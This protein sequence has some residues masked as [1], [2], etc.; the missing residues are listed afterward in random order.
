MDADLRTVA[1]SSVATANAETGQYLTFLLDGEEYGV[2]ILRVQEIK[3]WEMVTE[4]PNTPAYLRGVINLRGSIVPIIDL[5]LRFQM[6]PVEYGKTTVVIVLKVNS[7]GAERTVGFV[8]DAV[9]DVCNIPA[10]DLRRPPEF[11]AAVR[12]EFVT[13]LAIVADKMIVLLDIDKLID[14]DEVHADHVA[15]QG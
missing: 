2:N 6:E 10:E 1:S 3:G 4:I 7:S 15:A 5:R 9:S 8:V 11:G 13:G 12:I 14:A